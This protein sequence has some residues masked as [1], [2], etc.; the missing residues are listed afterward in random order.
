VTIH[1]EGAFPINRLSWFQLRALRFS[2][3]NAWS[4]VRSLGW[5][6]SVRQQLSPIT[7]LVRAPLRPRTQPSWPRCHWRR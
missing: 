1:F 6:R 3:L 2:S 4:F 5:Q 7:S